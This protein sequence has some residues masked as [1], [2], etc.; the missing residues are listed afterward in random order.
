MS[1]S[2]F[3]RGEGWGEGPF[4]QSCANCGTCTPSP[5]SLRDPTSP[6]K[7]R[8]V[9]R[10]YFDLRILGSHT[11]DESGPAAYL[12]CRVAARSPRI[13]ATRGRVAAGPFQ[14]MV[15]RAR[16]VAARA[17]ARAAREGARRPFR[18]L[19]RADR[20]RQDVGG[21]SADAG[22]VIIR[23]ACSLFS[24]PPCGVRGERSS[25]SRPGRGVFTSTAF[26]VTPLPAAFGCRPPPQGG[27]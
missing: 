5:G 26:N 1:L 21:I 18:A 2:P 9:K 23:A 17:S 14:E 12:F 24:L 7:R 10:T 22:G 25:L 15:R 11:L 4:R 27:R 16:L 20:R 19:D 13:S 6:R 8:E 3:L